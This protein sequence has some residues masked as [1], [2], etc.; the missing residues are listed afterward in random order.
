MG[1]EELSRVVVVGTSAA[2]K[3]TFARQ[4][5]SILNSPHVEL[6]ALFWEANWTQA[7]DEVFRERVKVATRGD[8]WVVDGNYRRQVSGL[9]LPRA[10]AVVWLNLGF[11]TVFSRAMGRTFRRLWTREEL[12]AGNR[13]GLRNLLDPEG[14]PLWVIRT[15]HRRRRAYAKLFG[16]SG[17]KRPYRVIELR[18]T[19]EV[20]RFLEKV[21]LDFS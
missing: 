9:F 10:T 6:D 12:W 13:E 20:K 1:R 2:G 21:R 3:T 8:R 15:F 19:R 5:S 11:R 18:T 14:I 16:D 7:T 4:L 17:P